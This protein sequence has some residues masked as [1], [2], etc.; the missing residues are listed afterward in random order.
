MERLQKVIAN[1]GIASRRHAELMIQQGKVSVNGAIITALGTTVDPF[2]DH[3]KVNGKLLQ[4]QSKKVYLLLNKPKGYITSV[5]DPEGRPTVMQLIPKS[6]ERLYPVGRLDFYTEG[7]LLLTND[8]ELSNRLM[9]PRFEVEKRYWAKVKGCPTEEQIKKVERG[10]VTIPVG[11]SAPCSIRLI[12]R[13]KGTENRWLELILHEGKKREVRHLMEKIAHP[14]LKLK[15]VGY[16]NLKLGSLPIGEYRSLTWDEVEG[17]KR[18]VSGTDGTSAI[19]SAPP[20]Q[21]HPH[22]RPQTPRGKGKQAPP[23]RRQERKA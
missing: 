7:L 16:G 13:G 11:K 14:V 22:I 18:L 17:L 19:I 20:V 6:K 8:G 15:R 3:I 4:T 12:T 5:S 9:H 23:L 1:A 10:G 21:R 2:K